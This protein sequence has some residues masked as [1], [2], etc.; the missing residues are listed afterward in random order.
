MQRSGQSPHWPCSELP[1]LLQRVGQPPE[2]QPSG[3]PLHQQQTGMQ[4][5]V[6][7][8]PRGQM[9]K[10]PEPQRPESSIPPGV[11]ACKWLKQHLLL[12]VQLNR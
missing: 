10:Q 1:A 7:R 3:Q 8:G 12:G 2:M 6:S 5:R 4:S 11:V 9:L